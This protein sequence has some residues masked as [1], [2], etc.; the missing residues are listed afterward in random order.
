MW[1]RISTGYV[2][3]G[4]GR[5]AAG[6]PRITPHNVIKRVMMA[7][8]EAAPAIGLGTEYRVSGRDAVGAA[9]IADSVVAHMAAFPAV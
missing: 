4:I 8:L 3:D 6:E 1:P 9:L 7:S 5:K 2:A